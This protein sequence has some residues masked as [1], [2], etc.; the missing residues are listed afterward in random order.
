MRLFVL[1][2]RQLDLQPKKSRPDSG[3][4][5]SIFNDLFPYLNH[6]NFFQRDDL[7]VF[8]NFHYDGFFV[9]VRYKP[10]DRLISKCELNRF[11][12][13][14]Q[15]INIKS[16]PEKQMQQLRRRSHGCAK[17]ERQVPAETRGDF[18]EFRFV[19]RLSKPSAWLHFCKG[20]VRQD[21]FR[22]FIQK[23]RKVMPGR[24][25][26]SLYRPAALHFRFHL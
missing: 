25:D 26:F 24:V 3:Q 13:Q 16:H 10:L 8:L 15:Q 2:N 20:P 4:L 19:L 7:N 5:H 23:D 17:I 18:P 12:L 21:D 14:E 6:R 11:G 1:E 22:L 9:D